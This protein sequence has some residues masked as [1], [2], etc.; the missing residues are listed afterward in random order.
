MRNVFKFLGL[1]VFAVAAAMIIYGV[2]GYID[3]ISDASDHQKRAKALILR[4]FG[5]DGL[6]NGRDDLLLLIQDPA[7]TSHSGVD[8]TTAGAGVTTLS[9][10][11]SKRLAFD[12]FKPGIGKIRQTGYALGLEARLNKDEIF[13]LWLDTVEMGRGPSGWM[14]GFYEAI[15]VIYQKQPD[16]LSDEQ[17]LRLVAVLIAPASYDLRV[18]DARIDERVAR[19]KRLVEGQCSAQNNSDVWLDECR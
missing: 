5:A 9:Q 16:R 18:K 15:E 7:F 3:A 6:G 11:L 14:T 17:F 2:K 12:D 10:S 13:A 1:T 8:I 19:I 4:G